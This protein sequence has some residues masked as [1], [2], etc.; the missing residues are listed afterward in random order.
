[1]R[2]ETSMHDNASQAGNSTD[3]CARVFDS[4]KRRRVEILGERAMVRH[5]IIRSE[6]Y[7]RLG[8][9]PYS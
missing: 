4:G 7:L 6:P 8:I 1:M 5:L 3:S 2:E 9:L